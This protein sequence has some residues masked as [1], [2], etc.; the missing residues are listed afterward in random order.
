MTNGSKKKSKEKLKYLETNENGNVVYQ[1]LWD[2]AKAAPRGKF[3][4]INAYLK[5][6]EKF[7]KN[8]LTLHP[9]ELE[10]E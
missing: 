9:E 4:V 5:K 6:Q 8:N 10:K 7:Q 2:A 1:N 3:I